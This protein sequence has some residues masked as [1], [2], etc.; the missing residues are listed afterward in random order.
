[1]V[2]QPHS[3]D[4]SQQ[5]IDMSFP[6]ISPE[7]ALPRL[8]NASGT[9]GIAVPYRDGP[10]QDVPATEADHDYTEGATQK[11]IEEVLRQHK[12]EEVAHLG[13]SSMGMGDEG[14]ND[15]QSKLA[16]PEGK[17]DDGLHLSILLYR[18]HACNL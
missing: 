17:I 3:S 18:N 13:E 14:P 1:M 16:I 2:R 15:G 7:A 4:I 8:A 5:P 12:A 6:D 11:E 9:R 10:S